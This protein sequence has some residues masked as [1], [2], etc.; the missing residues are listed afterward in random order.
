MHFKGIDMKMILPN[1]TVKKK[2]CNSN[3]HQFHGSNML[4]RVTVQHIRKYGRSEI[5]DQASRVLL[6]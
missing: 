5:I 6:C 3:H 2:P 4:S 1:V